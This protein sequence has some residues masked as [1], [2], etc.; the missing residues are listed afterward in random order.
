MSTTLPRHTTAM[1]SVPSTLLGIWISVAV[2]TASSVVFLQQ[3][4]SLSARTIVATRP[5]ES[6]V[7]VEISPVQLESGS[8]ITFHH[9]T[10]AQPSYRRLHLVVP[11]VW[12][13]SAAA[14]EPNVDQREVRGAHP[15]QSCE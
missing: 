1:K 13:K 3:W 6:Q 4:L 15:R 14:V 10:G 12:R 8:T 11:K 9:R 5:Q 2:S 7:Y